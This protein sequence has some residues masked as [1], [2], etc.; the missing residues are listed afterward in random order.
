[1]SVADLLAASRA[2]HQVYRDNLPQKGGVT[3]DAV[4]ARAAIQQAYQARQDAHTAD[5]DKTDP[6]WKD[7]PGTFDDGALMQFYAQQLAR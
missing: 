2:F 6:A 1:M 5:P 4:A 7:E 3:G